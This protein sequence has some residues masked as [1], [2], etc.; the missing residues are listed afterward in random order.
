MQE[1]EEG[2]R[3]YG[4]IELMVEGNMQVLSSTSLLC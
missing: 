2:R 3:S 4:E 1:N